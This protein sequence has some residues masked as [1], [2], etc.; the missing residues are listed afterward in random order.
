MFR[1]SKLIILSS[2]KSFPFQEFISLKFF[3]LIVLG[4]AWYYHRENRAKVIFYRLE[5]SS[6]KQFKIGSCIVV[7]L[8]SNDRRE[9]HLKKARIEPQGQGSSATS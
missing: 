1:Y 9:K 5:C 8:P 2:K 4:Q 7:P 6:T 3:S